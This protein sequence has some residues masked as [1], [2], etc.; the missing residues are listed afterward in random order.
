MCG[1]IALVPAWRRQFSR[2]GFASTTAFGRVEGSLVERWNGVCITRLR[3]RT[4]N[5]YYNFD[6]SFGSIKRHS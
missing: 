3:G 2:S 5:E 1:L 6:D 4:K